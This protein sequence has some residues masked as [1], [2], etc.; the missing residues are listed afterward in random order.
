VILYVFI[1]TFTP[2]K[3]QNKITDIQDKQEGKI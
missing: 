1:D 3:L 2:H